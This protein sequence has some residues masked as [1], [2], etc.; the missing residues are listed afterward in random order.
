MWSARTYQKDR[1]DGIREKY[2]RRRGMLAEKKL[3][4]LDS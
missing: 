4:V 2:V 3:F 1:R